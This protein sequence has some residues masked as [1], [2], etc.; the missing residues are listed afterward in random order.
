MQDPG[1]NGDCEHLRE[2]LIKEGVEST[3][4]L[5]NKMYWM[6]DT[7]PHESLPLRE[8]TFRQFFRVVT[9]RV[10]HWFQKH[11]TANPI[12]I[13]PPPNCEIV[14]SDKFTPA[15]FPRTAGDL[16]VSRAYA[17]AK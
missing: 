12:G 8:R 13:A 2:K 17:L 10:S 1:P 16:F 4:L 5:P 14:L 15:I 9:S 7:I 6:S 11:S 3:V